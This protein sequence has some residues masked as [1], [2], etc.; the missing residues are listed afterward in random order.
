MS[1]AVDTAAGDAGPPA[2]VL[3]QA[4]VGGG[5]AESAGVVEEEADRAPI[6]CDQ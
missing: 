1:P 5:V 6:V 2:K 3:F 4:A